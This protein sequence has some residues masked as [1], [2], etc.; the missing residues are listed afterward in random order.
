MSTH[1]FN[2]DD[3][4]RATGQ[5]AQPRGP[6]PGL[7][8]PSPT[9]WG[10][11]QRPQPAAPRSLPPYGAP[12]AARGGGRGTSGPFDEI[13]EDQEAWAA[14]TRRMGPLVSGGGV[15]STPWAPYGAPQDPTGMPL[16]D[17]YHQ[18]TGPGSAYLNLMQ[19]PSARGG[20]TEAAL[21]KRVQGDINRPFDPRGIPTSFKPQAEARAQQLDATMAVGTAGAD[22]AAQQRD[23]ME[24]ALTRGAGGAA[25]QATLMGAGGNLGAVGGANQAALMAMLQAQAS[26]RGGPTAAQA[27]LQRGLDDAARQQAGLAASVR[28]GNVASAAGQAARAGEDVLLRGAS[29]A[30]QLRAQEQQAAQQLLGTTALQARS[31]DVDVFGARADLAGDVRTA[32]LNEALGSADIAGAARGQDIGQANTVAQLLGALRGQD[33][34]AA[35]KQGALGLEARSIDDALRQQQ[36][37]N[38]LGLYGAQTGAGA[39]DVQALLGAAGS[40]NQMALGTRAADINMR[41]YENQ[42]PWWLGPAFSAGGALIGKIP[43]VA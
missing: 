19:L 11:G 29:D 16:W 41:A 17:P 6:G 2:L 38:A 21:M 13:P 3:Y 4:N 26:G 33:I 23:M 27:L 42:A 40:A 32:G 35:S 18:R 28:G 37:N 25:E 24:A 34:D 39:A 8:A 20:G 12:G 7:A 5:S 43:G 1:Y 31:G 22:F 30:A 36:V 10:G 14:S 15:A 9:P